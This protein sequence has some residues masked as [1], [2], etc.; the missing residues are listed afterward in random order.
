MGKVDDVT[1]NYIGQNDKFADI[2]NFFLFDGK[3]NINPSII[4][5]K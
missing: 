5:A 1:K 3:Q 4:H 2:C